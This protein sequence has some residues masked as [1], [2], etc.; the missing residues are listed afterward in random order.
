MNDPLI[1]LY[2][3]SVEV[4]FKDADKNIWSLKHL[5]FNQEFKGKNFDPQVAGFIEKVSVKV[6]LLRFTEIEITFVPPIAQAVTMLGRKYIGLGIP[7]G[8]QKTSDNNNP[9]IAEPVPSVL[10]FNQI[11]V[12]LHYGGKSSNYFRAILVVPEVDIGT[13]GISV[14]LKATGFLFPQSKTAMSKALKQHNRLQLLK[15]LYKDQSGQDLDV[16]II[17]HP[18]DS[19]CQKAMAK[20]DTVVTDV[21]NHT[22]ARS[23][24]DRSGCVM[25]DTGTKSPDGKPVIEILSKSYIRKQSPSAPTFVLWGQ[26]NPNKGRYPILDMKTSLVNYTSGLMLGLNVQGK[27]SSTKKTDDKTKASLEA[28]QAG[29]TQTAQGGSVGGTS[30]KDMKAIKKSVPERGEKFGNSMKEAALNLATKLT[31]KALQYELTVP[32]IVDLMPGQVVNVL[33]AGVGFL[34]GPYDLWEVSHSFGTDGVYS[35]LTLARTF[36]LVK[37][38]DKGIQATERK[39]IATVKNTSS[40]KSEKLESNE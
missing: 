15:D 7:S 4:Y 35:T 34:S 27:D 8:G 20:L 33:V 25:I 1:D 32:G 16:D 26:I 18:D 21:N 22:A 37:A 30:N 14:T 11:S 13:D 6:G 36:G 38:V 40:K 9:G 23:I 39:I 2:G 5:F 3:G 24:L 17:I 31:E 28:K 10:G 29:G 19:E 12:R